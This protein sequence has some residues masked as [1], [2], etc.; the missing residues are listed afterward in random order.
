MKKILIIFALVL[1]FALLPFAYQRALNDIRLYKFSKQLDK[2]DAEVLGKSYKQIASGSEIYV[3]G[4]GEY[5]SFRASR[6]FI[7]NLNSSNLANAITKI[8]QIK[9]NTA[10]DIRSSIQKPELSVTGRGWLISVIL[11]DGP[12]KAK[13]D[14]RCW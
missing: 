9:F 5:C 3:G 12:Y 13:F 14:V 7:V 1:L 11:S 10:R 8:N 4:N 6:L 2:I